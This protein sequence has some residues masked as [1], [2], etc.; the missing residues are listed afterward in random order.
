[1]I[2]FMAS[3]DDLPLPDKEAEHERLINQRATAPVEDSDDPEKAPK[4]ELTVRTPDGELIRTQ[5]F[6]VHQGVN[7]VVWG[8]NRDGVRPMPK[9]EP[10][11]LEDGLPGGIEVP[12]GEYEVTLSLAVADGEPVTSSRLVTVLPDPRSTASPRGRLENYRVMLELK[13]MQEAAVT[14]VERVVH[15]QADV[16]TAQALIKQKQQPGALQEESL[17]KLGEQAAKIQKELVD[18]ENHVRVPPKTRGYVYDDDKAISKIGMAMHYVGSSD[19]APSQTADVYID[20]ARRS[21]DEATQAI[22]LYMNT[23]LPAFRQSLS[24]AGIGL[25]TSSIEP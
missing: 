4:V 14:A 12:A 8:M 17:K 20:L 25:F 1:M 21:L 7:R 18:L 6:D 13:A 24:D 19:D 9:P 5:R 23:E 22:D 16:A 10:D 3:G 15:A 2:T 11:D